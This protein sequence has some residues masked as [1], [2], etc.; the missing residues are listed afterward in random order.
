MGPVSFPH[1]SKGSVSEKALVLFRGR[2][3][4]LSLV[5]QKEIC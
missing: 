4:G 3:E 5:Q 2:K 1:F